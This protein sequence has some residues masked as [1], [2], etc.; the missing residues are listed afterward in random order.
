MRI[1]ELSQ[2]QAGCSAR[3]SFTAARMIALVLLSGVVAVRAQEPSPVATAT[4]QPVVPAT[5]Q[6]TKELASAPISPAVQHYRIGIGDVLDIRVFGRPQ[7]SHDAVR[8]D[9]SGKIRMPLQEE[10]V[11]ASCRTETEL[12]REIATLYLK[13]VRRPQVD[14][15]IRE[16]SSQPVA[17]IGAVSKPGRFQLQRPVRLLELLTFAGGPTERA[18]RSIQVVHAETTPSCEGEALTAAGGAGLVAYGLTD[19]LAGRDDANPYVR[20]GDVISI[21]EAE[22]VFVVGNVARPSSIPLK[23]PLTVS[24]AIAMAGGVSA[25]SKRDRIRIIRQLAASTTKMEI[26]VDLKAIEKLHATDVVLQANDIVEVP[27]SGGKR[28]LGS[29]VGAIVPTVTQ[30]PVRVIP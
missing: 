28:L 29:L 25:Y 17:V 6:P 8:V 5:P 23:E 2:F 4:P 21:A 10:E 26:F 27:V 9:G 1:P 13:Y 14:V 24:R 18:G 16:Y 30:L 3:T 19:A 7:L 20:P 15:F 12:A 22:Q 11:Q